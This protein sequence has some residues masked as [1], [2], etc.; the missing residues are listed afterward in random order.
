MFYVFVYETTMRMPPALILP[1]GMML[2][3]ATVAATLH[4]WRHTGYPTAGKL[5]WQLAI[6]GL[7]V[8][9]AHL[10]QGARGGIPVG[11]IAYLIFARQGPF[12]RRIRGAVREGSSS[13]EQNP[14][15]QDQRL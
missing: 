4:L 10:E 11:A 9:V 13:T 1:L 7:V 6:L 5:V 3:G 14:G 2:A 15:T 12:R 8:G